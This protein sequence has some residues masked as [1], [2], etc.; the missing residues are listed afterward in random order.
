[1]KSLNDKQ[2]EESK[3]KTAVKLT[4]APKYYF[5]PDEDFKVDWDW[6]KNK[7]IASKAQ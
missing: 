6:G 2:K 5:H 7:A 1:M 3:L 4:N